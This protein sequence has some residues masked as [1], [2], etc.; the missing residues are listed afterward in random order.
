MTSWIGWIVLSYLAAD[1]IA[2][3]FH[4]FEDRYLDELTPILGRLVG[5]PNKMHHEQPM[6]MAEGGY[7]YR[8]YTTIVPAAIGCG[9]C[10][11]VPGWFWG[12]LT[13]AFLTQANEIHAWAHQKGR[14]NWFIE[15]LQTTGIIQDPKHH[16]TH[17]KAPFEVRYC[18]MS[19][20]LNPF[21][22]GIGFWR[23]CELVL[24]WF[25][26]RVRY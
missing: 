12:W 23:G 15:A 7:W 8:N 19:N 22:D 2:G 10:F 3:A 4:W 5:G 9:L 25:G 21:L 14:V 6:A 1:F 16:G 13:F 26:L 11:I 24:F 17:H 20:W 18:V